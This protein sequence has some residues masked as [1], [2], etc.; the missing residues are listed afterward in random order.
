MKQEKAYKVKLI[1]ILEILRQDSDEDHYVTSTELISKLADMGISCDRRTLYNDIEVLN[2]FGYEVLSDKSPGKPNGYCVVDRSFDVPELRILMD[3][4]QASGCITPKKT[5][6]LIDK[7]ADLGGSHR[8][9]L[10]R[11]NIVKFNTTKST[12]ES[13]FYSVSEINNAIENGKKISF[14]YFDFNAKHE[15][16]YRH[17][18]N[19]YVVNPLATIYDAGKYYLV[20]YYGDREGVAHYRIDRMAHV[21]TESDKQKDEYSGAPIDIGMH[22]KSLFGMFQG[23]AQQVEFRADPSILDP[24]FDTF[25][26]KLRVIPDKDGKLFFKATVQLSP[27]FFGW[28]LSFGDKL[29]VTAPR[30][31]VEEIKNYVL[32]LARNYDKDE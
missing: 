9:E 6:V 24:I 23:T 20:G 30:K 1:K 32:S 22:K 7:I 19:R 27:T 21:K 29:T 28:C 3:A 10:L 18:G 31:A 11:S 17:D 12:N 2:E 16:V 4:V 15:R 14:E 25:G 26:E 8:A 5:E 13:I